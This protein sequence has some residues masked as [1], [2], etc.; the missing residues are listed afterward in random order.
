MNI[1]ILGGGGIRAPIIIKMLSQFDFGEKIEF[2]KI[3]DISTQKTEAILKLARA[4]L[5]K[6]DKILNI[7][8]CNS[9]EEF[10][11]GLDAVVFTIR[12]GFEE[13]RA[14]DERIC[15]RHNVI[16]QETTGAAGFSF[17]A[18]SIPSLIMYSTEITKR[19]PSCILINFTNPAG[20]V[21]RALNI[22]GFTNV[23]GICDSSDAARIHAAE[24]MKRS[25]FD[26]DAEIIGLNHLSWTT[27]L[28][29]GSNDILKEL[30]SSEEFYNL[31]HGPFTKEIFLK[32]GLFKNEYLYYY[33]CTEDAL[34]G[35]L[36]EK[37]TRGEYLLRKNKELVN[38]LLEEND[39]N[40]LIKIYEDYLNDRFMTYMSYAYH[41]IKR[42]LV[43]NES[44]GYAEIALKIIK[45]LRER[46]ELN[47]PMVLANNGTIPFLPDEYVVEKFCYIRN[48]KIEANKVNTTL[49]KYA[50]E[51]I[52]R[53]AEY[54]N[55]AAKSIIERSFSLAIKALSIHP[56]IGEKVAESLLGEFS[57][58]H[59]KYF[60][61][62]K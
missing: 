22:V 55:L 15:L 54:E 36:E 43:E 5:N 10:A 23:I 61:D 17:A 41:G 52:E 28:M 21:V 57:K 20:I 35:M 30:L 19:N 46:M 29:L 8:R 48:R 13:G 56:L 50:K 6:N 47:I 2:V 3:Y 33:Y 40:R 27:R 53:V 32:D 4:I 60:N 62:F 39:P 26:F 42:R 7:I 45:A 18:R 44:E 14:I 38:K 31:A 49:P 9:I 1:G 58:H 11:E 24:L 37:E 25:R 34:K 59:C 16:G 12:E 51:I